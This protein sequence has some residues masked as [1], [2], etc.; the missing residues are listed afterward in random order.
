MFAVVDDDRTDTVAVP[1]FVALAMRCQHVPHLP[2]R[3]IDDCQ[4][5]QQHC[6][7][8]AVVVADRWHVDAPIV[9]DSD[10][11]ACAVHAAP[12]NDARWAISDHEPA[13]IE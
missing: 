7:R 5:I 4:N 11:R 12:V 2:H 10:R 8:A 3:S 9:A 6:R 1:L 13:R